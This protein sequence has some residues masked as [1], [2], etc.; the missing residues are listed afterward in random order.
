MVRT[1]ETRQYVHDPRRY[2]SRVRLPSGVQEVSVWQ[3]P[4]VKRG[5]FFAGRSAR[6]RAAHFIFRN[7]IVPWWQVPSATIALP[8]VARES[9]RQTAYSDFQ[10]L[11]WSSRHTF[12]I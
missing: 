4:R 11:P 3:E 8:C 12:R 10:I 5:F 1:N 9:V 7:A 2:Q 6:H